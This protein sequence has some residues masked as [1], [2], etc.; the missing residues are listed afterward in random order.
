[1]SK[2]LIVEDEQ[3]VA[4]A[5]SQVLGH[6]GHHVVG[7]ANDEASALRQ[8][9][10]GQPDLVLMDIVLAHGSDGVETARKMQ[11]ERPV[12]VLFISAHHDPKTRARVTSVEPVGFLPKP[13]SPEQLLTA[14]S[15]AR[16]RG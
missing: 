16:R 8:A 1:M 4:E 6:A 10:A 11:A 15:A 14:V 3:L 2:V 7:I 13:F 9:A 12:S 5:V